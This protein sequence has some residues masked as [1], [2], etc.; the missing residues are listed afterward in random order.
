MSGAVLCFGE[1]ITR[2]TAPDSLRL[3]QA[4]PGRMDASFAGAEAN[5]AATIA[6][7]GGHAEMVT[8][9]PENDLAQACLANLRNAGVGTRHVRIGAGRMGLFFVETGAN[10]RPGSVLYDRE[11]SAFAL[12]GPDAYPWDE[13]LRGAAWLHTTGISAGVSRQ[14]AEATIEAARA[15]DAAGLSVSFDVNFRRKLWRWDQAPPT[16]LMRKTVARILPHVDILIGNPADIAE[17]L[18]A[19][20]EPL[21]AGEQPDIPR[22]GDLAARAVSSY[23]NLSHVAVTLRENHSA[24]HNNWGALLHVARTQQALVAPEVAGRYRPYEV[25]AMVDRIGAGDAFAGALITALT[26]PKR[27]EPAQAL[28]FATAASCLAHSVK[29]DFKL[30][31]AAEVENL[32]ANG[33]GGWIA[34]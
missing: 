14:A 19:P 29:G 3:R 33:G 32:L 7:L 30:T 31:T 5:A 20:V 27:A 11:H 17:C 12:A 24:T 16:E 13:V 18:G 22:I 6:G 8:L 15:A 34:R 25:R 10:Q 9:L 2:L 1:I 28:A 4:M 21:F 23:R 26:T